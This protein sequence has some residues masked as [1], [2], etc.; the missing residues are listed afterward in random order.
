MS[1]SCAD[2][3]DVSAL[4]QSALQLACSNERRL[5]G[6]HKRC[7]D[8]AVKLACNK[9]VVPKVV[10]ALEAVFVATEVGVTDRPSMLHA[11]TVVD[12]I[13]RRGC[14]IPIEHE[15][16]SLVDNFKPRLGDW[17]RRSLQEHRGDA[18]VAL[19][20]CRA[21]VEG[22]QSLGL[23]SE[24]TLLPLLRDFHEFAGRS[25]RR[26]LKRNLRGSVCEVQGGVAEQRAKVPRIVATDKE[27]EI[28][29][30]WGA[31][32]SSWP[33]DSLLRRGAA[34][35]LVEG[36]SR[37]SFPPTRTVADL[38][39]RVAAQEEELH[40]LRATA[41]KQ[42]DEL[43]DVSATAATQRK[44]LSDFRAKLVLQERELSNMRAEEQTQTWMLSDLRTSYVEQSRHIDDLLEKNLRQESC[45]TECRERNKEV[46]RENDHLIKELA[47]EVDRRLGNIACIGQ[48]SDDEL[49]SL[50]TETTEA[51]ARMQRQSVQRAQSARCCV[52]CLDRQKSLLLRPCNHM[53]LCEACGNSVQECPL[54]RKTI[55]ERIRVHA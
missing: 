13:S 40:E 33:S 21:M 53:C 2:Q 9:R 42:A 14:R 18:R 55:V 26:Q 31:S 49:A 29:K 20:H 7:V 12:E 16:Q 1:N 11:L 15:A 41:S 3:D 28:D 6:A 38:R 48:C 39:W 50:M 54:C 37:E 52:V 17:L 8:D 47:K 4:F 10:P 23:M 44:K 19:A 51:L 36:C 5:Y 25:N 24:S 27:C 22:W 30:P 45:I 32:C 35:S 43:A 34:G 46:E